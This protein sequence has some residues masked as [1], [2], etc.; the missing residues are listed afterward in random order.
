MRIALIIAGILLCSACASTQGSALGTSAVFEVME[1]GS[2]A[3]RLAR[4][5]RLE[6]PRNATLSIEPI[7]FVGRL[8]D[9]RPDLRP[10]I[11]LRLV[12]E[13]G[14]VL[15]W[16]LHDGATP[17]AGR[18]NP[19]QRYKLSLGGASTGPWHVRGL[20]RLEILLAEL[21]AEPSAGAPGAA[22]LTT[23]TS[24]N[25]GA[26]EAAAKAIGADLEL[27]GQI[28][29]MATDDA[30]P[31]ERLLHLAIVEA[32]PHPLSGDEAG[33]E[34]RLAA[35]ARL[36]R[37]VRDGDPAV[38]DSEGR[39]VPSMSALT[40]R[41]AIT[42]KD[43]LT[44]PPPGENQQEKREKDWDRERWMR[45]PAPRQLSGYPVHGTRH[46]DASR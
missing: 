45:E 12:L 13:D 22:S 17:L 21:D 33:A 2:D 30:P 46:G 37:T 40:L 14:G 18:W 27:V 15:Q 1:R 31:G 24:A 23:P 19:Q 28:P 4:L 11:V 25:W 39:P 38:A 7:W 34:Q 10:Q 20:A 3:G 26:T 32:E 43:H 44:R 41:L 9:E 6:L 8:R 36:L 16:D 35:S 42:I 29:I 5:K